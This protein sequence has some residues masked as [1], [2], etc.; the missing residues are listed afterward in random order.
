MDLLVML[1]FCMTF[2]M[3]L[4]G[5]LLWMAKLEETLPTAVRRTRLRPAPPP[6]L[7]VP[8]RPTR[9]TGPTVAPVAPV[10]PVVPLEPAAGDVPQIPAQRTAPEAEVVPDAS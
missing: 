2:P 10:A 1:V 4:L 5:F 9:A 8:V 7:A 3:A 6:V